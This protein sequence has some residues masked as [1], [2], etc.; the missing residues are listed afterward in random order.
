MK[1][2]VQTLRKM[3]QD[4][5]VAEISPQ[6]GMLDKDML[7]RRVMAARILRQRQRPMSAV[8]ER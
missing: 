7:A 3:L 1:L 2:S 5:G 4:L 6:D 8:A